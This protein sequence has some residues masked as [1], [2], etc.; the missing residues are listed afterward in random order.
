MDHTEVGKSRTRAL[1]AVIPFLLLGLTSVAFLLQW[2]LDPLWA[3][4]ILPPIL[5]ISALAW[6]AFRSGFTHHRT[7]PR[8]DSVPDGDSPEGE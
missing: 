6:I 4:M 2:G 5:F 8:P 3:V 1:L 7:E